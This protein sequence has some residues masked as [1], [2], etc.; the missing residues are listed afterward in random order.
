MQAYL[1]Y[2]DVRDEWVVFVSED[3]LWKYNT[4]TGELIRLTSDFGIVLNPKI[5]P[6]K[7]WIAFARYQ[8]GDQPLSEVYVIPFN[9]G[10]PKR[11]TYFGSP[12]TNVVG[13]TTDGKI[14]VKSDFKRPF[15]KWRELFSIDPVT[16]EIK[17]LPYGP[18]DSIAF[19]E[20]A[21]VI[22]RN[23]IDLP[24]WKGYKGGT[25]GR[26]YIDYGYKG[27]FKPFLELNSNLTSPMWI[28]DRFYF[29]SDHEGTGN[30]YSVDLEGNDLRRHTNFNEYY[31]RNASSDGKRIVFQ[32]A[33]DIYLMEGE[34]VRKLEIDVPI[35]GKHRMGKFK[36]VDKYLTS[37]HSDGNYFVSIVRGKA[38]LMRNWDG[39]VIQ[40]GDRSGL[41]RYRSIRVI[42]DKVFTLADENR[43]EVYSLEGRKVKEVKARGYVEKIFPSPNGNLIAVVNN[44]F[45]LWIIDL[46]NDTQTLLDKAKWYIEEVAWH[47]SGNWL[48][49]TY[50]EFGYWMWNRV[51]ISDLKTTKDVTTQGYF[52][53]SLSFDPDGKYLYFLSSRNFEAIM[54]YMYFHYDFVNPVK[55]YLVVLNKEA[56]SPFNQQI[57]SKESEARVDLDGIETRVSTI[58]IDPGYYY[59]IRGVKGGKVALLK[60]PPKRVIGQRQDGVIELF[61][62]STKVKEQYMDN[63]TDM[64]AYEDNIVI[65]QGNTIRVLKADKKPEQGQNANPKTGIIDLSRI[66]VFVD[67]KNEWR[68]MLREAWV[69]MKENYWKEDMN[70][71]NWEKVLGK[72]ERLI[73]KVNTR[74]EL[75]DLIK[76]MQGELRTSHAYEISGDYDVEKPYNVG[77]LGIDYKYNGECY[78]I[79]EIFVG[80]PNEENERSPLLDPGV[81]AEIGDCIISIDGVKLDLE[82]P[83]EK[84][85][86]NKAGDPV[87]I[88]LKKKSGEIKTFSVRTLKNEKYVIYRSWV[89]RNRRYVNSRGFGY[90]H[91]PD[92]MAQGFSEFFRLYTYEAFKYGSV[93]VDIRYNGGGHVSQL[94]LER[95]LTKRIAV[96]IPRRGEPIPYPV[97][98]PTRLV[99]IVNEQAGSDADI[100]ANSFKLYKLGKVIGTRTWGG[101][102]GIDSRYSLVDGTL[103]TQPKYAFWFINVGFG[104]ENYGVDPD[105]VVDNLPQ[106]YTRGVDRQLEV[107]IE[108]LKKEE[109]VDSIKLFRDSLS[110]N[111]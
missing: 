43:I 58:P 52:N 18:A 67:L 111:S 109:I 90:I 14:V 11:L 82:N 68:Q 35:T 20:K 100:F 40:L 87:V 48:A 101:V 4:R 16:G 28:G 50:P 3:D 30:I 98:A 110:R 61:D 26:F 93:V 53:F 44:D 13:W 8:P 33:G 59:K 66:K 51:R 23:T 38:F 102:V 25:R 77:G 56:F 105:I 73:D 27:E 62:F 84:L 96:D 15:L 79:T 88:E 47:P 106:D 70:G 29:I 10:E 95:L 65:R 7:K 5:S 103:V 21:L 94:L 45:E 1:M 17:R 72:Y 71:I 37:F 6:D 75:S 41:T 9:G 19:G 22:G 78:E 63:V 97:V 89:E 42:K 54:D 83:P 92:M 76:E 12:V 60:F 86:V 80:D 2:P 34:E 57:V 39:P 55:A 46:V 49:Y 31:V 91:I 69:L 99:L 24:Y 64:E 36:E 32:M 108:E 85:L 104:V 74:Y 81:N 107:A